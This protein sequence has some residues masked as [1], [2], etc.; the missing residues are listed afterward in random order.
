MNG[1]TDILILTAGFGEG[2]NTAARNIALALEG[3]C[4]VLVKDPCA[5]G[6]PYINAKLSTLYRSITHHTPTLWKHIYRSTERR[7]FSKNYLP[8]LRGPRKALYSLMA[9]HRPQLVVCTYP[10]Y[11]YFLATLSSLHRPRPLIFTVITDSISVNATWQK[12]PSHQWFVTDKFTQKSLIDKGLDASKVLVTG[13]P[14]HPLFDSLTPLSSQNPTQPF[15]VLYFPTPRKKTI[16]ASCQAILHFPHT[17]L[18]LALGRN[19]SKLRDLADIL[20]KQYGSRITILGWSNA[21][22]ELLTKHHLVLGKAGGATVHEAIGAH[23]PMFINYF[24]PGQEEGN[25][26]LLEHI[27]G[28]RFIHNTND[29]QRQLAHLFEE[30]LTPWKMM[31]SN[32][33][34]HAP[35][36][37]SHTIASHLLQSLHNA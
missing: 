10:L 30:N 15:R 22:P 23:C 16:I 18:T 27:G 21:I 37:A 5:L 19:H 25:L 6:A 26:R 3:K 24:I 1:K 20:K 8:I 7:D 17:T 33:E 35:H 32:L 2:H 31:K 29:L 34:I 13:F 36:C 9:K 4:Q 11:P 12:A 14:I 28:G